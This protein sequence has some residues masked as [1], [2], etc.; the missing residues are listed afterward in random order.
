MPPDTDQILPP[1]FPEEFLPPLRP[2]IND[3]SAPAQIYGTWFEL[4]KHVTMA[5][6][7]SCQDYGVT[8]QG[9][10]NVAVMLAVA[11]E[12]AVNIPCRNTSW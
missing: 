10:L 5:L 11:R 2:Q 8:V 4:P 12:H 7:R 1:I 9:A 3:P 6:M